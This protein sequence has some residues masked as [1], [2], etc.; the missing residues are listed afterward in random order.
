[1]MDLLTLFIG[2][3][4]FILGCVWLGFGSG[5]GSSVY[6]IMFKENIEDWLKRIKEHR[7]KIKE[8]KFKD[9]W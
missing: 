1:M 9:G 8:L 6:Q 2:G 7:H 3:V 5:V 4:S